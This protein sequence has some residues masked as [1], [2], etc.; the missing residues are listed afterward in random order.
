[1]LWFGFD[2]GGILIKFIYFELKDF[3][4]LEEE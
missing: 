2:I 4:E 3:I 1:M